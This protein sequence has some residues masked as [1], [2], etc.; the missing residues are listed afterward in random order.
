MSED[1]QISEVY[2]IIIILKEAPLE[3]TMLLL[4][5][6]ESDIPTP[7]YRE[8]YAPASLRSV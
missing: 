3:S 7:L 8:Q 4:P 6:P 5:Y 1:T 2:A